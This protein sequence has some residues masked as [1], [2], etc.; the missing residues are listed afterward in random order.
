MDKLCI[1]ASHQD[2]IESLSLFLSE[3]GVSRVE[4]QFAKFLNPWLLGMFICF[5]HFIRN[6]WVLGA[7]SLW[8]SFVGGSI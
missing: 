2:A 8:G 6:L 7:W 3:A 5:F 1:S 4:H